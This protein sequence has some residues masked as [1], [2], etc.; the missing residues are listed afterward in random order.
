VCVVCVCVWCVSPWRK[1]KSSERNLYPPSALLPYPP[2]P[3]SWPW[4][5]PVLRHI[6]FAI[7][8]GLSSQ[9]WRTGPSSATYAAREKCISSGSAMLLECTCNPLGRWSRGVEFD[10]LVLLSSHA[11]M[12]NLTALRELLITTSRRTII[13]WYQNIEIDKH[14]KSQI[15]K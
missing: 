9:W 11:H 1:L 8:R 14:L 3:A 7:P 4:R 13:D 10:R 6:K 2:T 5:S 12:D 15:Q